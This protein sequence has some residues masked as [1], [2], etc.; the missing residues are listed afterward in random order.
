MKR[1]SKT[2]SVTQPVPE[3]MVSIAMNCACM[4]VGKPGYGIVLMSTAFV[5]L[6]QCTRMPSTSSSISTPASLSFAMTGFRCSLIAF[7]T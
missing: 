3:E 7:S 5:F 1:F 6:S 2:V 4:S